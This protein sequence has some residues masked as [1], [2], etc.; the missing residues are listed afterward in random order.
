MTP[1][2][3]SLPLRRTTIYG[4]DL[5][6]EKPSGSSELSLARPARTDAEGSSCSLVPEMPL[7]L[8]VYPS[9]T[10]TTRVVLM[11][12]VQLTP[13]TWTVCTSATRAYAS[14][15]LPSVGVTLPETIVFSE[16]VKK[17]KPEYVP[18]AFSLIFLLVP[19][20]SLHD[21]TCHTTHH[22][23]HQRKTN[24]PDPYLLGAQR[25]SKPP[26]SC[27][28][29]EDAPAGIRSG[30]SAGCKTLGLLTTHGRREMEAVGAD[31]IVSDLASVKMRVVDG[32][33]EVSI[34][35]D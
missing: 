23:H 2:Y 5:N 3:T 31:W 29:V 34:T 8:S 1:Y 18:I 9:F 35:V 28:V 24:R 12:A 21:A 26:A 11:L 4:N 19:I 20:P 17:G 16:D 30:K 14:T 22:A 10:D 13:G 33:V 7:T 6:R 25:L 27:L 32:R 15:A